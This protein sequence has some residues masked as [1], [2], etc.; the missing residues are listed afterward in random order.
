MVGQAK[1]ICNPRCSKINNVAVS[2]V[3]PTQ[4]QQHKQPWFNKLS[5]VYKCFPITYI[6][7]HLKIIF[8]DLNQQK[9]V[10]NEN[11]KHYRNFK[12]VL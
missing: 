9:Y 1:N 12:N 7:P 11:L 6:R 3:V 8:S 5:Y 2:G 4:E 10:E